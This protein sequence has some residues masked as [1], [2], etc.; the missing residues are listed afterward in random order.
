MVGQKKVPVH[1]GG[2]RL[3]ATSLKVL[4]VVGAAAAAFDGC[5]RLGRRG[6]LADARSDAEAAEAAAAAA[7]LD[8]VLLASSDAASDPDG[9]R[10]R[11]MQLGSAQ[12]RVGKKQIHGMMLLT[13]AT[14]R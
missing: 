9:S 8:A 10:K 6:R 11:L 13:N 14:R 5:R 4:C 1:G 2:H 7:L 3:I 12:V